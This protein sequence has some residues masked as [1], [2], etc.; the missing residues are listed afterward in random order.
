M[1]L[2]ALDI[3]Q[4][5]FGTARHGY[6]PQEVDVFLER[7][8]A[9]I[10]TFNTQLAQADAKVKE[11]EK[12]AAESA[13]KAPAQETANVTESQISKAF[14]AAQKSADALKE[15]ARKEAENAYR[16]AE[17][18]ARDIVRDAMKQ[19]KTILEEIDTLRES[20]ERFRSEYKSLLD[21]FQAD[22]AKNLPRIDSI[23][24]NQQKLQKEIGE[25]SA[26]VAANDASVKAAEKAASTNNAAKEQEKPVVNAA[27]KNETQKIAT[28]HSGKQAA[29]QEAVQGAHADAHQSAVDID[30]DLDIEEID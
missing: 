23:T 25:V 9:E 20:C 26:M 11:A 7:V 12:R 24:P 4:Q 29:A 28:V 30:D 6:D 27:S 19:K 13:R 17:A 1:A 15:E 8:A 5:S 2:T 3:Q 21:H 22:A 16:E 18:N 14:I 10:D